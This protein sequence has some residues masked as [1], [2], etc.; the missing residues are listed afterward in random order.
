MDYS[1]LIKSPSFFSFLLQIDQSIATSCQQKGCMHCGN[2]LYRSDW[3][4]AGFGLP[5]GTD[6]KAL[7]R[8]SFVCGRCKKRT[9][10]CS[11]RWMYYRWFSA[12]VQFLLPALKG[13]LSQTEMANLCSALDVNPSLV[14]LWQRWWKET[15]FR[16]SY[17]CQCAI[18]RFGKTMGSVQELFVCIESILN[19]PRDT[20]KDLLDLF[21]RYRPDWLWR[22]WHRAMES[23]WGFPK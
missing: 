10:P 15:F 20:L 7:V 2:K 13:R 19:C 3:E 17:W 6:D 1:S 12:P 21:S 18:H 9:T 23:I 4:R 8:H 22:R 16:S 11:L 5:P 14:R